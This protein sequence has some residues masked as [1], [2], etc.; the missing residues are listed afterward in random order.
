MLSFFHSSSGASAEQGDESPA[1]VKYDLPLDVRGSSPTSVRSFED[2]DALESGDARE[3]IPQ[4]CLKPP[5]NWWLCRVTRTNDSEFC[6]AL[7]TNASRGTKGQA[8][9]FVL[10]AKRIGDDFYISRYEAF[11]SEDQTG[12]VPAGRY[13]AVLRAVGAD[14]LPTGPRPTKP[15]AGERRRWELVS[16]NM[17]RGYGETGD[18]LASVTHSWFK[19]PQSGADVRTMD[20]SL[21]PLVA[22]GPLAG[23]P[24][25]LA[26]QGSGDM[27]VWDATSRRTAAAR[28]NMGKRTRSS[29]SFTGDELDVSDGSSG[30]TSQ[31]KVKGGGDAADASNDTSGQAAA[32]VASQ[33]PR[34]DHAHGCLVMKFLRQRVKQSSAKNMVIYPSA[35]VRSTR[36]GGSAAASSVIPPTEEAVMQFGKVRDNE[37][38]L[39]LKGPVAPLQAFGIALS[40]FAFGI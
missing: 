19:H 1:Q 26:R 23:G 9:A 2:L 15:K 27:F 13:C 4:I 6:M 16:A 17:V 35:L 34:W 3:F 30:R 25:G 10:S 29:S 36:A 40:S 39:D 31:Q 11:P 37:Y 7:E 14:G 20:A 18:A 24:E 32:A 22:A 21:E 12:A 5:E 28:G 38:V 33:I 8:D